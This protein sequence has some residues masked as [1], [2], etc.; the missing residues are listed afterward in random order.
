MH[1][2]IKLN[3]ARTHKYERVG[4]GSAERKESERKESFQACL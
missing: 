1:G 2:H 4:C 3:D